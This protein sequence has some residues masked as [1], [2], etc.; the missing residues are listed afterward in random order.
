[1]RIPDVIPTAE[2]SPRGLAAFTMI[3]LVVA[4]MLV[5]VMMFVAVPRFMAVKKGPMASALEVMETACNE[6]R[7]RAIMG[8]RPMQV[9]LYGAE[10]R[11]LVE[12]APEGVMGATNGVSMA[13][14]DRLRDADALSS[15][16]L[17]KPPFHGQL[18]DEVAF[19]SLRVN[20]MDMMGSSLA[21][22]RFFPNG[23]SDAMSAELSWLKRG[24]ELKRLT[25]EV[26][27]ARLS[28][29]DLR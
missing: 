14:F 13:S 22:I 4:V 29:E 11:V 16:P 9:V 8:N 28:I 6:A 7:A 10:G 23:T 25:L 2:R 20:G 27:T 21:A 24:L 19:R 3:E 15:G 26:I 18:D 12:P 1:M 5:A 17:S